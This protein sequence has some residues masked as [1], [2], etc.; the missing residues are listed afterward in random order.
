MV[1][2]HTSS[3]GSSTVLS[4]SVGFLENWDKALLGTSHCLDPWISGDI[5]TPEWPQ[6]CALLGF[7]D[8]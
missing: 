3:L 6:C 1:T 5:L 4:V 8:N 7:S 2:T